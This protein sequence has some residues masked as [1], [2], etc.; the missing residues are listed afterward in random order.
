[1][2]HTISLMHDW[3]NYRGIG[4]LAE[5]S[6]L[7]IIE[8]FTI[9]KYRLCLICSYVAGNLER[10]NARPSNGASGSARMVGLLAE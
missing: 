4:P 8:G 9:G 10:I 2:L 3:A 5:R 1:M 7:S 6:F